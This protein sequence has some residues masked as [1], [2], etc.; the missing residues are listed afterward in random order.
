M[1]GTQVGLWQ[2]FW[3]ATISSQ[4]PGRQAEKGREDMLQ[5]VGW[6]VVAFLA[7][8]IVTYALFCREHSEQPRGIRAIF[9]AVDTFR[10]RS[11]AWILALLQTAPQETEPLA[12]GRLRRT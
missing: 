1:R 3:Q 12:D 6:I 4:H 10:G 2:R 11:Y 8:G 5:Y 7:G 9:S